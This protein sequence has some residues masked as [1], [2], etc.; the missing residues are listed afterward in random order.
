MP[1]GDITE[2]DKVLQHVK[3]FTKGL[4]LLYKQSFFEFQSHGQ[5]LYDSQVP[6]LFAKGMFILNRDCLLTNARFLILK[7]HAL[8]AVFLAKAYARIF[9][10]DTC[11]FQGREKCIDKLFATHPNYVLGIANALISLHGVCYIKNDDDFLEYI[12]ILNQ[13]PSF[14]ILLSDMI[15]F[16][17]SKQTF[18]FKK[19]KPHF[20]VFIRGII[21]RN[22]NHLYELQ[23]SLRDEATSII[24][25][26]M[27]VLLTTNRHSLVDSP[28]FDN[29]VFDILRLI[30]T[31]ISDDDQ[32]MTL[33][34]LII[35][36]YENTP[37][38]MPY[39]SK[40]ITHAYLEADYFKNGRDDGKAVML[41]LQK[42][43]LNQPKLIKH[44]VAIRTFFLLQYSKNKFRTSEDISSCL[45]LL[46]QVAKKFDDMAD[47]SSMSKIVGIV[48]RIP[49]LDWRSNQE[50]YEK[51]LIRSQ[52]KDHL[53]NI[54]TI[55]CVCFDKNWLTK[56]LIETVLRYLEHSTPIKTFVSWLKTLPSE[57]NTPEGIIEFIECSAEN[58]YQIPMLWETLCCLPTVIQ[59]PNK[60]I[61]LNVVFQQLLK[62][63]MFNQNKS[64]LNS[65]LPVSWS[66]LQNSQ[67]IS[68]FFLQFAF[69]V[70]FVHSI[71]NR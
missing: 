18:E 48:D 27:H 3:Q 40:F 70:Q 12:E 38:N 33:L 49:S 21:R 31:K 62:D 65:I 43:G 34:N 7:Q 6:H 55:V 68:L 9:L 39:M 71:V 26:V 4:S 36:V 1:S 14:A 64:L 42:M 66:S 29:E 59:Q 28:V 57:Y 11:F 30:L 50:W 67:N 22:V 5:S 46:E 24:N 13:H 63:V 25:L 47:F 2:T 44:S 41:E 54:E 17:C 10:T 35:N 16:L 15:N 61:F 8:Y 37:E 60:K 19:N 52:L 58:G 69:S 45:Q 20:I 32:K 51:D 53:K 23:T 56:P